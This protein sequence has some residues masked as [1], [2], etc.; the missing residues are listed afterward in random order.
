MLAKLQEN[1]LKTLPG[2]ST[3]TPQT[4]FPD[5]FF[6]TNSN[7]PGPGFLRDAIDQTIQNEIVVTDFTHS[8]FQKED[9]TSPQLFPVDELLSEL[10]SNIVGI[11]ELYDA[12][13]GAL[14]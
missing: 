14:I 8:I 1:G 11:C 7:H 9:G 12:N 6:V 4:P 2:F 10:T 5:T 13:T 3:L